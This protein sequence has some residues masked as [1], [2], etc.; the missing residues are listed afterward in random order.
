ML[1]DQPCKPTYKTIPSL[2]ICVLMDVQRRERAQG[3]SQSIESGKGK[4][5]DLVVWEKEW[6]GMD[7]AVSGGWQGG[8]G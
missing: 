2:W 8:L 7:W 1:Q 3:H 5:L 6:S 4:F